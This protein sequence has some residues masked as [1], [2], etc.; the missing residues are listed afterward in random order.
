M[1]DQTNSIE[2]SERVNKLLE[3]LVIA[4][5]EDN[6]PGRPAILAHT[7]YWALQTELVRKQEEI[8]KEFP[9]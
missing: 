9:R 6:L 5:A 2:L 4:W 3:E 8:D 1:S 7:V